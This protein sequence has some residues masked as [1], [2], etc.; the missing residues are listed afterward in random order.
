[1]PQKPKNEK[2]YITNEKLYI[3]GKCRFHAAREKE[4]ESGGLD[5]S[6]TR[7]AILIPALAVRRPRGTV[8]RAR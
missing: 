4:P 3:Y 1:L 6:T 5:V 2:L 7:G 8:G